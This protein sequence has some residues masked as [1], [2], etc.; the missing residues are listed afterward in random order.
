MDHRAVLA[1]EPALGDDLVGG[2]YYRNTA[3]L[4]PEHLLQEIHRVLS[5]KG[6]EIIENEEVTC[7]ATNK[8]RVTGVSINGE[9]ISTDEFVVATGAWTPIFEK[10]LGCHIP[11][12]PGKGYSMT[13]K[14]PQNSLNLPVFFEEKS[15]VATPWHSGFRLGGTMEFAGYESSLTRKRLD[16]LTRAAA[17]YL[18][19]FETEEIE[20][21][22]C[23]FRPMTYDGLP[24]IDRSP[25][26]KNVMIAAGHN[27]VGLSMGPGTGKLVAEMLNQ[28]MP[29]IDPQ[30][31]RAG[32]FD[33]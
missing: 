23:G 24:I 27:M 8:D 25:R 6:V 30:P 21:E 28:D 10:T 9:M 4:R 3:R 19:D 1:L 33:S 2:W 12:Q 11:I 16:M 22:W 31:Y 18:R 29:H 7:F 32:R 5:E 17:C 26:L 15:V 13:M 14:R 20:E